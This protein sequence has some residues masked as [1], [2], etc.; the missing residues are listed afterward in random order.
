MLSETTIRTQDGDITIEREARR[1]WY[2]GEQDKKS[3]DILIISSK[4]QL[5]G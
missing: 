1:W 2:G 3:R 4:V 5:T